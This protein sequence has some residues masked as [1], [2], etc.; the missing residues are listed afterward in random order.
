MATNLHQQRP[1]NRTGLFLMRQA[2]GLATASGL[3]V[4]SVARALSAIF[5][6]AQWNSGRV[7][8]HDSMY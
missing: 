4:R 6:R 2:Y 5:S 7:S 8:M 3:P 1:G